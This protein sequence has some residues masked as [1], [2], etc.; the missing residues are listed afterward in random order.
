LNR[1]KLLEVTKDKET[2]ASKE[3]ANFAKKI[4]RND[5][6][7]LINNSLIKAEKERLKVLKESLSVSIDNDALSSLLINTLK[8]NN[9]ES[10]KSNAIGI[11]N[12]AT[13]LAKK[14]LTEEQIKTLDDLNKSFKN[15]NS[16]T[17]EGNELADVAKVNEQLLLD[18]GLSRV[19]INELLKESEGGLLKTYGEQIGAIGR[20]KQL[21]K[22]EIDIRNKLD[23][24]VS[25]GSYIKPNE[26]AQKKFDLANAN[27]KRIQAEI[28]RLEGSVKGSTAYKKGLKDRANLEKKLASLQLNLNK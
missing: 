13:D 10:E 4:E 22:E 17:K 2:L 9:I 15:L 12:F 27:I 25:D 24:A 14:N 8:T 6:D 5:E 18:L 16:L 26:E 7:L 23:K 11:A 3:A 20:L 28:S 21:L 19:Q 1:K